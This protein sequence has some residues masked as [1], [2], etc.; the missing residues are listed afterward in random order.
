MPRHFRFDRGR[1]DITF[2]DYTDPYQLIR[3]KKKKRKKK[4]E[5]FSLLAFLLSNF[6][7]DVSDSHHKAKEHVGNIYIGKKYKL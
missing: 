2:L 7:F 4:T 5:V 6:K 1:S 3:R